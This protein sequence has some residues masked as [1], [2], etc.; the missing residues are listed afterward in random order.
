M[1]KLEKFLFYS[2]IL[3]LPSQLAYHFW[4]EYAFVFGVRV[5][6]L[7]PAIYF[8]DILIILLLVVSKTKVKLIYLLAFAFLAFI[9]IFY[10]ISPWVSFWKW[11]KILEIIYLAKYAYD[12]YKL[13]YTKTF[14]KV[15]SLSFLLVSI[16]GIAQFIKGQTIGGLFYFL[17]ER[18]FDINT[19]GI[20]LQEIGGE[21]YMRIY[22][23][24]S[25]PNSLA[26]FLIL[27][28]PFINR[29]AK[30]FGVISLSLT[31]SLSAYIAGIVLVI[32]RKYKTVIFTIIIIVSSILPFI[33]NNSAYP[34]E[35]SERLEQAQIAKNII[36]KNFFFGSGLNSFPIIN[37]DL[38]PVHNVYLLIF[39]EAG[40]LGLLI[41]L[42]F[43]Y[44]TLRKTNSILLMIIFTI[45]FFDH[46]FFTL[47]QN[48][49]SVALIFGA[50]LRNPKTLKLKHE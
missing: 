26:G 8:T 35:I 29:F 27:G 43:I 9:N 34:P 2:L 38:Q 31:F 11:L 1:K 48:L 17:G 37:S 16:L 30:V 13:F 41:L 46:Y 12:N 45:S 10:S 36:A 19:P 18:N 20:A 28:L 47:Q 33:P 32:S 50:I 6:Y 21:N 22:S 14:R 15:L 39:A 4:P 42:T 49:L 44:K 3:F 25:H 23:T 5:D 24:F 40:A 7:A